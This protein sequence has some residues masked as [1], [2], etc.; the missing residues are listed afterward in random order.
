M[1]WFLVIL[2]WRSITK[3]SAHHLK[4]ETGRYKRPPIPPDKRLCEKCK[5][6]EDEKHLIMDCELYGENRSILMDNMTETFTLFAN[7]DENTKFNYIMSAQ[8][9][10]VIKYLDQFLTTVGVARGGI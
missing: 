8:D 9:F 5:Q 6:I 10:E 7:M 2:H 3:L 4:I 1:L